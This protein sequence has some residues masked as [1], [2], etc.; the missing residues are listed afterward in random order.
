MDVDT[1]DTPSLYSH[2][3]FSPETPHYHP[4]LPNSGFS[5]LND[6]AVSML[7]MDDD[8]RSSFHS[9]VYKSANT[10]LDQVSDF[11]DDANVEDPR[12]SYLGP[13]MRYHSKA[14]WEVDIALKEEEE[15]YATAENHSVLSSSTT[16]LK[17]GLVRHFPFGGVKSSRSSEE[18]TTSRNQAK[19]S[20]DSTSSQ[21]SNSREAHSKPSLTSQGTSFNGGSQKQVFT[22]SRPR[23]HSPSPS[24]IS[25]TSPRSPFPLFPEVASPHRNEL[26]P[27]TSGSFDLDCKPSFSYSVEETHPYANP[28][29][30]LS[31]SESTNLHVRNHVSPSA[32]RTVS[33][34]TGA[35]SNNYPHLP[36]SIEQTPSSPRLQSYKGQGKEISAPILIRSNAWKSADLSGTDGSTPNFPGWNDRA[37]SPAFNLISLEEARAQRSRSMTS[38]SQHLPVSSASFLSG[39]PSNIF[40]FADDTSG[41]S[42]FGA[43]SSRTRARSVSAG[44]RAAKQALNNIVTSNGTNGIKIERRDS[45]HSLSSTSNGQQGGRIL[46]N[47]RSGFLRLFN[48]AKDDK[49]PPPPVP[50]LSEGFAAFNASQATGPKSTKFNSHR[51]PVPQISPTLLDTVSR[52]SEGDYLTSKVGSSPK[53]TPPP[54]LTLQGHSKMT[55]FMRPQAFGEV[56]LSAP[57]HVSQFPALKLRPVSAVF[58]AQFGDHILPPSPEPETPSSATSPS[59]A[60]SPITPGPYS[61]PENSTVSNEDKLSSSCGEDSAVIRSLQEQLSQSKLAHR[62]QIWALEGQ[63]RDLRAELEVERQKIILEQDTPYCDKCGRGKRS[64]E[65]AGVVNRPRA[66]TGTGQSR[67]GSGL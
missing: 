7:D 46:K 12:M 66:R 5:T 15:E 41:Q 1:A 59:A 16:R 29:H 11:E 33:T 47:K 17:S 9:D 30:A 14:P 38:S 39:I 62:Q 19:V 8:R 49:S 65:N 51:I 3:V 22:P 48:G 2:S 53:R 6:L 37:S 64:E 42:P 52:S 56:P 45:E 61:R 10:S 21:S 26:S 32:P 50:S 43:T 31:S 58:S 60:I 27:R 54:P 44:A 34:T 13:K 4:P 24:Q 55:S 23:P 57:A 63:V 18:S 20:L 35:D 67:F 28:D 25:P 36:V 40:P